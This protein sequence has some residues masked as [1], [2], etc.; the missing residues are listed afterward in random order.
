MPAGDAN[1]DKA[2]QALDFNSY[3]VSTVAGDTGYQ[4]ADFNMD[5]SVQ[6]LDFNLYLASTVAGASSQVP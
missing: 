4:P 5:G 2:V 1:A 6:A 3:L